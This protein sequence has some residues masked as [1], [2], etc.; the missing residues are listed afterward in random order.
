MLWDLTGVLFWF[1]GVFVVCLSFS[2][3]FVVFCGFLWI[4]CCCL[5]YSCFMYLNCLRVGWMV[6]VLYLFVLFSFFLLIVLVV[7]V[8]CDIE[9]W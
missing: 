3:K 9:S 4:L 8:F 6:V 5:C 7:C 2:F 1:F